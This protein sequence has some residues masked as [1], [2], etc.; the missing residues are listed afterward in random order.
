MNNFNETFFIKQPIPQLGTTIP[1]DQSLQNQYPHGIVTN[2]NN[3]QAVIQQQA[4]VNFNFNNNLCIAQ[5]NIPQALQ[6]NYQHCI[7]S[8][9]VKN[10]TDIYYKLIH[11]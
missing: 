1:N 5:G 4:G 11:T 6:V 8:S 2:V 10:F 3:I 7:F 9:I